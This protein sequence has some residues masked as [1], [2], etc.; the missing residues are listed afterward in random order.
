MNSSSLFKVFVVICVFYCPKLTAQ[1][2]ERL[3]EERRIEIA[4]KMDKAVVGA[5]EENTR[6]VNE[7]YGTNDMELIALCLENHALGTVL[8]DVEGRRN[9]GISPDQ[10][11]SILLHASSDLWHDVPADAS[12]SE[13]MYY[14]INRPNS[15][16][17]ICAERLRI[18][19][20]PQDLERYPLEN[21]KN[22]LKVAV[23]FERAA[24][25]S[26]P[27]S[28]GQ[29]HRRPGSGV[30]T[31]AAKGNLLNAGVQPLQPNT[32]KEQ[33]PANPIGAAK[34]EPPLGGS[35]IFVW[36]CVSSGLALGAVFLLIRFWSN[37]QKKN[38]GENGK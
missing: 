6:L 30:A 15:L 23:L 1:A 18:Y 35:S 22:R 34:I 16:A 3:S 11:V 28:E 17:Q 33:N 4:T 5:W 24:R 32:S 37:G 29:P 20:S 36:A 8:M 19:V 25:I 38:E 14:Q 12:P 2:N 7:I 13:Q 26:N 31:S 27:S 21:R 9:D 10:F